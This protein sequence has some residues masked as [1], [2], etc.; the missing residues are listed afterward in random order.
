MLKKL[1]REEKG[2]TM[3]ELIIVIAIIG[4]IGAIV[5]PNFT[6]TT[7]NSRFKAD[8]QSVRAYNNAK[9]LYEAERGT[10]AET[11]VDTIITELFDEG[12]L[13]ADENVPQLEGACYDLDANINFVLNINGVN[14]TA[15]FD[16]TDP[17]AGVYGTLSPTD[18]ALIVGDAAPSANAGTVR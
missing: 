7:D 15:I 5:A 12:Y 6:S 16:S 17:T 18:Q 2:F 1:F 3:I 11:T 8:I 14:N 9:V 10:M 13:Q 4:I